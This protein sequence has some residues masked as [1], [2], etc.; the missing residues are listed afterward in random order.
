MAGMNDWCREVHGRSGLTARCLDAAVA[1]TEEQAAGEVVEYIRRY[2]PHPHTA[3]IAGNS[4]HADRKFLAKEPWAGILEMLHY[5]IFDVSSL[6]EA[7][8]RW[9]PEE[10]LR[11]VPRKMTRHTARE[12]ILESIA[13]ARFYK[14]RVFGPRNGAAVRPDPVL[15]EGSKD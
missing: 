9:A 2:V 12:D 14:D 4:I 1:V 11:D 6:K 15:V 13:E 10:V 7:A 3:L 8:S 5:R